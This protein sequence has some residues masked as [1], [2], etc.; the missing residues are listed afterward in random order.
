MIS[1]PLTKYLASHGPW[2]RRQAEA[3]I[4]A[5][6]VTID[7]QIAQLGQTIDNNQ[8]IVKVD[9]QIVANNNEP[10]VYFMLN[11]PVGYTCTN[12]CFKGERNIFSLINFTGRLF[13]VGRLDKDSR[14]L[15]LLTNDGDLTA[16]LTHP[17]FA[18]PK[19]YQVTIR[20][21]LNGLALA[22]LQEFLAR[23]CRLYDD[24]A[25]AT[26]EIG[27]QLASDR[28]EIIL[29]QGQ[30]RQIRLL[31]KAAGYEVVDLKRDS[32]AG[33]KLGQLPQGAYR[34]LTANEIDRLRRLAQDKRA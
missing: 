14:G 16:K 27:R 10:L 25:I 18:Q 21:G 26:A 8:T 29:R 28:L 9:S 5:G 3:L 34:P 1:Q 19:V 2:S 30:K 17:R 4:R 12:R 33:L 13:V 15:V 11:K 7:D 32:L 31:M 23:G 24:Q 20:P 22:K 6:R